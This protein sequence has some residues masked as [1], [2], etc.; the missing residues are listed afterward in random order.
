MDRPRLLPAS[1]VFTGFTC[2]PAMIQNLCDVG[3]LFHDSDAATS[4]NHNYTVVACDAAANP[5]SSIWNACESA[6]QQP[7]KA[8]H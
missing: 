4:T 5:H 7:R 2:V 3:I 6:N 1:S 8:M